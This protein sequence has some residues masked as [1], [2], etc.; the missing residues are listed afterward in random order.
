MI[1]K[2][3][4][5]NTYS[6]EWFLELGDSYERTQKCTMFIEISENS[7]IKHSDLKGIYQILNEKN[8]SYFPYLIKNETENKWELYYNII[9]N[10]LAVLKK[11]QS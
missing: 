3:I 7:F 6:L 4:G 1:N 11:K 5:Y 10:C 8:K 9:D 2:R